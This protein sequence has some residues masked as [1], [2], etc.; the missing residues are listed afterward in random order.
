MKQDGKN[1]CVLLSQAATRKETRK[2]NKGKI[3]NTS[4]RTEVLRVKIECKD[5]NEGNDR[6]Q[7]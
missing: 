6:R 7:I 5:L 3:F 4:F 2:A 1:R